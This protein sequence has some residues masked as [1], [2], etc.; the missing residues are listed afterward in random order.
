MEHTTSADHPLVG[1]VLK[2]TDP[3]CEVL[4][5][6]LLQT[7]V[8]MARSDKLTLATEERRVVDSEEHRHCRFVDSDRRQR[9][10]ILEVAD[11][12][13]NLKL[14][15][16]DDGTYVTTLHFLHLLASHTVEH[17]QFLYLGL[18]NF[19]VTMS[20]RDLLSLLKGATMHTS[21]GDTSC[22]ARIVERCDEHLRRTLNHLRSRYH[23]NNLV[24]QICY[25]V[26]RLLPVLTHP[27]V[28]GG[29]IHH[30]EVQLVLS[31]IEG[32]HQ[33]EHHLINLLGS[34]VRLIYLVHH[35]NRFESNLQSLLQHE[36]SLR[37]RSLE[38]IHKQ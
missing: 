7:V 12:I 2:L 37:H 31:G 34:A 17:M 18:F 22:I 30:G 28:L 3:Q 33:V 15:Q 1:R 35:D 38:C 36:T 4:L 6:L 19:S 29:A 14:L 5:Q 20:D 13:T 25:I 26:G 27:S 10:R 24:E 11:G 32:E 9:L 16:S 23:L 21:H 8:D